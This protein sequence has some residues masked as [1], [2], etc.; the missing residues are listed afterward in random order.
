MMIKY[1]G[2]E[3]VLIGQLSTMLADKNRDGS[4]NRHLHRK[5]SMMIPLRPMLARPIG[6]V[7]MDFLRLIPRRL[8]LPTRAGSNRPRQ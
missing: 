6:A 5:I 1:E 3:E 2:R 4:R 8:R 7:K